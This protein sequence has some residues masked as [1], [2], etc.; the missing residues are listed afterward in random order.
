MTDYCNPNN[1]IGNY[2][3]GGGSGTITTRFIDCDSID[4]NTVTCTA[5][6]VDGRSIVTDLTSIENATQ[7]Q[8]ATPTPDT[9]TFTGTVNT[10]ALYSATVRADTIQAASGSTI[11]I[12]SPVATTSTLVSDV[13]LNVNNTTSTGNSTLSSLLCPNMVS[14]TV[15]LVVGKALTAN[16]SGILQYN[17]DATTVANSYTSIGM[18]PNGTTGPRVYSTY[19]NI[20]NQLQVNGFTL[21]PRTNLTMATLTTIPSGPHLFS[22]TTVTNIRKV[23]VSFVDMKS[24]VSTNGAPILNVGS[25]GVYITTS[26]TTYDGVCAGNNGGAITKWTTAGIPLWNAYNMM[27]S[28]IDYTVSGTVEFTYVGL[29]G[30]QQIWTVKGLYSSPDILGAA[31]PYYVECSGSILMP[32]TNP[33]FNCLQIRRTDGV[34]LL[35]YCNVMVY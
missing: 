28:A 22:F 6:T 34:F 25:N 5:L 7:F 29:T 24:S 26:S 32:T 30:T 18:Y 4:S 14:G 19:T 33:T 31:G 3:S 20:P 16:N 10:D 9:T 2:V 1:Q 11:T 12:N 8:T 35:G 17:Y 13:Q 23:V 15:G 21:N 27:A